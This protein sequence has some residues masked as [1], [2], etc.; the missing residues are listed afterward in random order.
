MWVPQIEARALK[1]VLSTLRG[2]KLVTFSSAEE[3]DDMILDVEVTRQDLKMT[4]MVK[5]LKKGTD[6]QKTNF[7]KKTIFLQIVQ[8]QCDRFWAQIV[9][10]WATF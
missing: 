3:S 6:K 8:E 5:K 2:L 7:N 4:A 10:N 9:V 1:K